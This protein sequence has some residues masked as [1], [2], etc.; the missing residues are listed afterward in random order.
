MPAAE[1]TAFACPLPLGNSSVIYCFPEIGCRESL[2]TRMPFGPTFAVKTSP[3]M[4][5]DIFRKPKHIDLELLAQDHPAVRVSNL[6]K[7]FK[8][9]VKGS[10]SKKKHDLTIT[11]VDDL[12]FTVPRGK[13]LGL[14]GPNSSGKTTTMRCMATLSAPDS[15][16]IQYYGIDT[17]KEASTVRTMLGFVAQSAGLDKVLTGR[18]HLELFGGLAHLDSREKQSNIE[19]LVELL[20]LEDFIDRQTGVYS[21]GVIRRLDLAIALL[22]QPPILILDEPTVGL[23]IETRR[24]I[25][26]VLQ[27]WRDDGGTIILSSHYLEEVDILSDHIVILEKG[28]MLAQGSSTELKASLGGDRITIRLNEF[29][30]PE[31]A[32]AACNVL[33]QRGLAQAAIVNRLQNNAVELVVDPHNATIGAE[34][35]QCLIEIGFER[36]FS[37][38]QSKPS[39]DDVYLAATGR[40]LLDADVQAKEARSDKAV[41]QENMAK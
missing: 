22:H 25:W 34:I 24:V 16:S 30:T 6:R 4:L 3:R 12:S 33:K 13:I 20:D 8:K 9:R 36:L 21:G 40:S 1:M 7:T 5:F 37:F 23:D 17:V 2:P 39:L 41:R 28:V 38:A 15:G 35:V 26:D 11:A 29:T 10:G 27:S 14:L 18:E 32:E 31:H 19:T